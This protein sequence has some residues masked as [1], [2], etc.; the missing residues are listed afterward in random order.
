MTP[1]SSLMSC[2]GRGGWAF[3]PSTVS[4][5]RAGWAGGLPNREA[6]ALASLPEL[7]LP[8]S[9]RSTAATWLTLTRR[10]RI[11]ISLP[12]VRPDRLSSA[13]L[14]H[15]LAL[16]CLGQADIPTTEF[17]LSLVPT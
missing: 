7:E 11:S 12:P 6:V 3:G 10:V 9:N 17:S 4:P 8:T 5:S 15:R 16:G 13:L 2:W 14:Q 1:G